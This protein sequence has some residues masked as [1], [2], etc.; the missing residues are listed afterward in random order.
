MTRPKIVIGICTF[1]RATLRDTLRSIDETW[2]AGLLDVE[3]VVADNDDR[4]TAEAL[5]RTIPM[6]MPVKVLHAPAC[7]ISIARNAVLDEALRLGARFVAFLDDDERVMPGWLPALLERQRQTGAEA[8][9]GPVRACY[10]PDAPEWMRRGRVHDVQPKVGKTGEP[11]TG[12]TSNVLL[13]LAAPFLRPLR[14]DLARG[15]TGGEDTAYFHELIAAGGRIAF[16]PKAEVIELVPP[17]RARTMWLVQRQFRMGQTH[18]S[19]VSKNRGLGGRLGQA[20][21]AAL[22][23]LACVGMALAGLRDPLA[24]NR[25]I[26]RG[27]LHLGAFTA[28]VGVRTIEIYGGPESEEPR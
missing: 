23:S 6:P 17:V 28:L 25:A 22:K 24:R 20:G 2:P 7:N 13:D 3:V 9:L 1:R 21:L 8:V 12:Y 27:T 26:L 19:L 16:A 10:A 18:A 5:V 15:R 11:V 14:F 4:P